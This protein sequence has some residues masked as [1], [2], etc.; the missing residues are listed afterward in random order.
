L[1]V[2]SLSDRLWGYTVLVIC[3]AIVFVGIPFTV[4]TIGYLAWFIHEHYGFAA[5]FDAMIAHENF[6]IGFWAF[7]GLM[8]FVAVTQYFDR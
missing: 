3:L 6:R 7:F 2:L 4:A 1:L 8:C 5:F